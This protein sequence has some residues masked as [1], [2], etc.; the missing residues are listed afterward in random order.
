MKVII[1]G[2]RTITEMNLVNRVIQASGFKITEVV[3]GKEP[4]G[5][6]HLGEIWANYNGI[7]VKPFPA[8]WHQYGLAAGPIRNRKMAEY[9]DA[10]IAI[11]SRL[12]TKSN[13]TDDMIN[14]AVDR[15]LKWC[16]YIVGL[17]FVE[18]S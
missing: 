18:R 15:G 4:R 1:A 5:V 11:R 2:S 8:D 13:G 3:S 17:G 16:V 14:Q 7:P 12:G 10:I 6:D 9:A